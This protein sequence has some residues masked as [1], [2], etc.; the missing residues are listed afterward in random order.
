MVRIESNQIESKY[1]SNRLA[2]SRRLF[3]YPK[4]TEKT[5]S[6]YMK[7]VNEGCEGRGPI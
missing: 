7:N 2:F 4:I 3:S 1:V 5:I 6:K